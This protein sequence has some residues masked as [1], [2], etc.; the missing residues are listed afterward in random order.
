M[1]LVPR[2][3][4]AVNLINKQQSANAIKLLDRV[5][6]RFPQMPD[7]YFYR[8]F[9]KLQASNTVEGRADL[10]KYVSLAPADAPQVTQAKE[11]LARIK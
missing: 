8:G 9:A 3:A 10:E 2:R 6:A 5:V 11:L 4:L 1:S 7:P